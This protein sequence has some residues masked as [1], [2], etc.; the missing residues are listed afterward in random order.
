M[1]DIQKW[2]L[3]NTEYLIRRPWL[4]AR[5]DHLKLPSGVDMPE[6]YVL[7]YPDWINIIAITREGNILM[8]RQYRH[9]RQLIAYELPAG[10]IEDGETP[11]Q[12]AQRELL[13]ETG[14]TGGDW[15]HFMTLCPNAGACNNVSHTFI[16]R[17]VERTSSPHLEQTEDIAVFELSHKE[18]FELL[19]NGE[20]HQALMSAP[21]WHYF[22]DLAQSESGKFLSRD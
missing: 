4:T 5:R 3:L 6:Y 10:V 8:E 21:L 15:S 16:V 19:Q 2:S 12:A 22:Y 9:A 18:V 11:L 14:Y 13:E 20:V 17:N 7:E 1:K